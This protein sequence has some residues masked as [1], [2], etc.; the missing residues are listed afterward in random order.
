[1]LRVTPGD[2]LNVKIGGGGGGGMTGG[3][4]LYP[5]GKG[6][7]TGSMCENPAESMTISRSAGGS[8]NLLKGGVGGD[9]SRLGVYPSGPA[10]VSLGNGTGDGDGGSVT[11]R[12]PTASELSAAGLST[13]CL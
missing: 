1:M 5:G 3:D 4:Y 2:V 7:G 10:R 8:G 9:I 11:F 12:S 13:Y 6:A